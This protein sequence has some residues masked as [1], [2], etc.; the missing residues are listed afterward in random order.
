MM[1]TLNVAN[2]CEIPMQTATM[3][4]EDV[5]YFSNTRTFHKQVMSLQHGNKL[6]KVHLCA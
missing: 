6:D 3:K 2:A 4:P 1:H 5:L